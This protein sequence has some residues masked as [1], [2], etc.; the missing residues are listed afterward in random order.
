MTISEAITTAFQFYQNGQL[1]EAESLCRQIL[2]QQPNCVEALRLLG[3][4]AHQ[5]GN[6]Q[7]A[8]VYYRQTIVLK[9]APEVHYSLG[10]A[11]HALGQLDEA[12]ASYQQAIALKPDYTDAYYDLGNALKEQ[13][14]LSAAISYYRQVIALN[15]DD[16]EAHGNLANALLEQG[17]AEAATVHYQQVINLKPHVP[18]VYYNLG[19][20]LRQQDQLETAVSYYKWAL[21]LEP[22]YADVY[23]QLGVTRHQQ[24]RFDD[25]IAYY[26]QAIGIQ[27]DLLDAYLNLGKTLRAQGK[28][29]DAISQFRRVLALDPQYLSGY[30]EL[31][32]ALIDQ[33][34]LEEATACFQ[35]ALSL[36]PSADAHYNLGVA[37]VNQSR[38][39][40]AMSCFQTALQL[41]PD[42]VQAYWQIQLLLPIIYDTE[43]QIPLWRQ[44]FCRG[45]NNLIQQTAL[46]TPGNKKEALERLERS[47]FTFFYLGYHGLNNRGLQRKYGKFVHQVMAANHSQ[48]ASP[49][50]MPSLGNKDKIRVGY[51]SAYFRAHTIAMLTSG[52]LKHCD[53]ERF[54]IYSYHIGEQTDAVT[55]QVQ[56]YSDG[57]HHI[58]GSLEAICQQVIADKLHILVFTD[59]G[60]YPLTT[61]IAGLRLAPIQCMAWGHP[62]T[63]GFPTIDYFLSSDLMEPENAQVHYSEKLVRLP[64]ISI[65]YEKPTLPELT[66]TRSDFQL[67]EDAVVYLSCQS[68]FKYLPQFDYIFAEIAQ[69]VPQAQ[70]AFIASDT[71]AITA[72]FQ[73]R[74]QRTFANLGLNSEDY[75]VFIPKQHR[76]DYLNLNSVA[77]IF[78]DSFSWSGGHTTLEAIACGLP[79]VTCPGEFMRSRHT[80][81]VLQMMGMT[82]MIAQDEAEY[83]EIAVHLGLDTNWRQDV[84]QKIYERHS[85]LYEDR[86]C[87]TALEFFYESL[88]QR[89]R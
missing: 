82:E 2:Q 53:R 3:T 44:R 20:A 26:Q 5:V 37:F 7:A 9:Q 12:I 24:G 54:E 27:P 58:Y 59:V 81:G 74:L 33:F 48:W 85:W 34:K 50:P 6:L 17:Q 63:S 41:K 69:R 42:F 84:V 30:Q 78:L 72:Q 45:L 40:E 46:D 10:A 21:V 8:T 56:S 31:G 16:A 51:L 55:Q 83:V 43:E 18:G 60:M 61:Q 14:D 88:V 47:V 57:F 80:Y 62:I 15:P 64:N 1:S 13:G 25:A 39:D 67:R 73:A 36:C 29:R 23:L 76:V 66:K 89:V 87:V 28:S 68:L 4:I 79:V 77:D 65:C 52:W 35:Q 32:S 75:C 86:T 70:F 71:A 19:N 38:V 11:L 49:L 22:N